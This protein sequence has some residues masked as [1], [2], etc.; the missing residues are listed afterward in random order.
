MPSAGLRI[1]LAIAV[2]CTPIAASGQAPALRGKVVNES[3]D[4]HRRCDGHPHKNRLLGSD[5]LC[6]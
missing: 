2:L 4:G 5:R 6:W 3:G 1:L